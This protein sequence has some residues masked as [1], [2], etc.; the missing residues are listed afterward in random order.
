MCCGGGKRWVEGGG[1]RFCLSAAFL[2]CCPEQSA[3]TQHVF[4]YTALMQHSKIESQEDGTRAL[5]GSI[6]AVASLSSLSHRRQGRHTF[7]LHRHP[8]RI[9][10]RGRRYRYRRCAAHLSCAAQQTPAV[11]KTEPRERRHRRARE[12]R[13]GKGRGGWLVGKTYEPLSSSDAA[14]SWHL[15]VR[16]T[17]WKASCSSW[18]Q[19]APLSRWTLVCAP[20]NCRL[21]DAK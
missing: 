18:P 6:S 14:T 11:S 5:H 4:Q 3:T 2:A 19:S 1:R 9:Q 16:D 17:C 7:R 21:S 10:L 15:F 20:N 8:W 13:K 12:T